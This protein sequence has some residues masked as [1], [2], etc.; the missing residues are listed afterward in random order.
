M[1]SHFMDGGV[2]GIS[3]LV[4]LV[5]G[6]LLSVLLAA[7]NDLPAAWLRNISPIALLSTVVFQ[8]P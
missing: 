3:L 1:P 4:E 6:I 7:V 5:T 8:L 2:T